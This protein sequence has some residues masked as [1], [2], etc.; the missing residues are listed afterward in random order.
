MFKPSFRPILRIFSANDWNHPEYP[1]T[2]IQKPK[3][4][5]LF[6]EMRKNC[7]KLRNSMNQSALIS[8]SQNQL[9]QR[10]TNP[11]HNYS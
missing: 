7:V 6:P 3:K 2:P 1:S 4:H 5:Q 10:I 11:I 8:N 9:E